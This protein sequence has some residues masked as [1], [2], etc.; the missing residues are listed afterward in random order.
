MTFF[1]SKIP[2]KFVPQICPANLYDQA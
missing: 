2:A 1:H